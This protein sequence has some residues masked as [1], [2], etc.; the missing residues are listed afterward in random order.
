MKILLKQ[1]LLLGALPVLLSSCAGYRLGSQLPRDIRTVHVHIATNRTDEPLL[2]T[3]VTQAVLNRLRRDG[4]L[5]V[6]AEDEADA[7][8]FVEITGFEITPLAFDPQNRAR[9][10]EYRLIL[11]ANTVLT[12]RRQGNVI[13]RTDTREGRSTFPLQ[14][15]LTSSK[16]IGIPPAADDLARRLVAAVTEAWI[17]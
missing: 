12:R 15:D 1:L 10:D 7:H 5:Q 6:V 9:P 4:S 16:R 17:D 11:R 13:V 2:E 8:M 14:G 3:E